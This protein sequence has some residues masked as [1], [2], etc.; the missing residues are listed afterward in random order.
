MKLKTTFPKGFILFS[1]VLL[2]GIFIVENI[3]HRFWLNDFR[4]YYGAAQAMI[5][6]TPVYGTL[7]ALG[8]GYF[9][10][11]PFTLLLVMPLCMFQYPVACIIEYMVLACS[12]IAL[13]MVCGQIINQYLF[14][15]R[16][17]KPGWI[18]S[19]VFIC[20]L[21]HLVRELHLGNINVILL[22]L[23][24]LSVYF[25][26][27]GKHVLPGILIAVV[28]MTKPFFILIL[29]PLV[30]RKNYKTMLSFS[31]SI[32]LFLVN[33]AVVIGFP[34]NIQLHREW[35]QTILDHNS[36]FPSNNTIENIIRT[37]VSP[38]LAGSA[39]FFIMIVIVMAYFILYF[40]HTSGER[41]NPSD[42]KIKTS[43][44]VMET[45]LLIAILPSIFKTDTQHFLLSVPLLIFLVYQSAVTKNYFLI[46]AL[47]LLVMMYGLNSS[48]LLG[49]NLSMKMDAA[50]ILGISNLF[51]LASSLFVYF[52]FMRKAIPA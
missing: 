47:F 46:G 1:S 42:D 5:S 13:F 11:S 44:L 20:S 45:F 15:E 14:Y 28:V 16:L 25:I 40:Y 38:G 36:S 30:L 48:D 50:G 32:I 23:L 37:Y 6:G 27:Q 8:S 49:K 22:L 41:K 34:K 31:V 43:N 17:K 21:N 9:K 10:Y 4:V 35:F 39:Q 18:L 12:I 19:V 7:F 52:K 29:L 51:I 3:N 24:C 2:L 33:P 26:L